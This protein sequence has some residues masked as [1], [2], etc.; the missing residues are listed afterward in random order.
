MTIRS[1]W[2]VDAD[3]TREDTRLAPIGA[4]TGTETSSLA[5]RAGV[6]PGPNDPL[7]LA[8]T[9]A[10][11]ATIAVGRA[12]VAGDD[13][14]GAYPVVVTSPELLTFADGDAVNPRVDTVALVIRDDPYDST[15]LTEVSCEIVTGAPAADPQP[16]V[17]PTPACLPLFDVVVGAGVSAGTGGIDWGGG[18][19]DRR[20][21][22]VGLGGIL[23]SP[24]PAPG[25]YPGQWRD[26]GGTLKRWDGAQ[27]V[28]SFSLDSLLIGGVGGALLKSSDDSSALVVDSGI[29]LLSGP[30]VTMLTAG[31]TDEAWS[32]F[33]L[34]SVGGLSWGDGISNVD[35]S[36]RRTG[37][38]AL[39]VDGD[40]H[41]DNLGE[42][43]WQ[44]FTPE[45]RCSNSS[46]IPDIGNGLLEMRYTRIGNTVFFRMG[47]YADTGTVFETVNNGN[48]YFSLP[49]PAVA[50]SNNDL[51]G[52]A[53]YNSGSPDAVAL[54]VRL[55]DSNSLWF[56]IEGSDTTGANVSSGIV[57]RG[58]P[59]E[60]AAAS[61]I[62]AE[63]FYEIL[64]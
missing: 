55:R 24:S 12:V 35:V 31:V 50:T 8:S 45:W 47:V 39:T 33:R 51:I 54:S 5:T 3:Q 63:G 18:V 49:L 40:L 32:R 52:K 25:A 61:D 29:E 57:D 62:V 27:W 19:T 46:E 58:A 1:V 10:M 6:V 43:V 56:Y 14:Q 16:P 7:T 41:A 60:W 48:W 20:D 11:T 9:G 15:G 22:V 13:A 17:M 26:D 37:D 28:S 38:R 64:Q 53:T 36:L 34:D 2:H 44:T 23:P 42:G 59:A 4:M 30:W 21:Y